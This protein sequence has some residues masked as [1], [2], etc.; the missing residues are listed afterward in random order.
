MNKKIFAL[1]YIRYFMLDR[2]LNYY[3][4]GATEIYEELLN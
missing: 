4:V 2:V 1:F 3:L